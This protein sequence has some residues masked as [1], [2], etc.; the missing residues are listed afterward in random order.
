MV[1]V[2]TIEDTVEAYEYFDIGGRALH[3]VGVS[4]DE[5]DYFDP[6]HQHLAYGVF[7]AF[8]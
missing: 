5:Y 7:G 8:F 1:F 6:H 2:C 4:D 3:F